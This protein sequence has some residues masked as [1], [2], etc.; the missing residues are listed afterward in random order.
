MQRKRLSSVVI[1]AF[2]LLVGL[3]IA[4]QYPN[5]FV[6][7][8]GEPQQSAET[9]PT[10]YPESEPRTVSAIPVFLDNPYQIADIA[11][12]ANPATVYIQVKWPMQDPTSRYRMSLPFGSFFDFFWG[13]PFSQPTQP[14]T[15]G[16]G[17]IIDESGIV[18]TNQHVVGS[19][20]QEQEITVTVTSPNISGDFKARILGSDAALD[21][22]VLKIEGGAGPFP[23]IPL[24]DS[25]SARQGEWVIAIG[26]PYG[27]QLD[28]TVTFGIL[29]AKGREI[30][31]LDPTGSTQ[32]YKNL[33][34]IDAA[35]NSGNSGGP[36]LNIKGEVIGI[37]TA[38]HT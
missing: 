16:S 25:D 4:S 15:Q 23:T 22:A 37:N 8:E 14:I 21:L 7:A 30:E 13:M 33:M 3:L 12:A 38:V 17:F 10:T 32:V 19:A 18:L 20:G 1:V 28:H 34:Q 26:N 9:A 5:L 27:R 6:S 31:I 11:E 2:L 24:G 35:I 29:S 36:L